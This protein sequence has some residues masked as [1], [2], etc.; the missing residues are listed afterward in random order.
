M[1][2]TTLCRA[3]KDCCKHLLAAARASS[4]AFWQRVTHYRRLDV[5]VDLAENTSMHCN[6]SQWRL[7]WKMQSVTAALG[8]PFQPVSLQGADAL[9]AAGSLRP[10]PAL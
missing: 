6:D 8:L 3:F 2:W 7:P 1:M 4:T 9:D 5:A 10:A